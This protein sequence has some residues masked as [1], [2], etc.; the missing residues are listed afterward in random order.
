[1]RAA[2]GV[3]RRVVSLFSC[4]A[5]SAVATWLVIQ[6]NRGIPIRIFNE[7]IRQE[8]DD[9]HRFKFDCEKWFGLP[10]ESQ[11]NKKY[12][13]D[14]INVFTKER[15]IKNRDGA[16]CT[17]VLKRENRESRLIL[18]DQLIIGYTA[19]EQE[20]FD[21]Y[22]D[23]NPGHDVRAPLI[24]YGLS[25]ADCLAMIERAGIVLPM[26][27]RLG[28]HNNNCRGCVKGGKGY[29]NKIRVDFPEQFEAMCK[30]QDMLGAGSYFWPPLTGDIGRISLRML[31]PDAGNYPDEPDISCGAM[32]EIVDPSGEYFEVIFNKI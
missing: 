32:C 19:E 23:A 16:T 6:E 22:I 10:I 5:A 13:G 21:K 20:R 2:D 3:V 11:I 17:R 26:M 29:W 31:P 28:Y 4:G 27:Y 18:G 1:M 8:H 25:K 7:E 14:I 24:E 12:D 30:V 9:N 15:W